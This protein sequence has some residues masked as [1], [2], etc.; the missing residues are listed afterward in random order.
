M[1]L[2]VCPH[3]LQLENRRKAPL[4]SHVKQVSSTVTVGLSILAFHRR[5]NFYAAYI[6]LSQDNGGLMVSIPL[7]H[8]CFETRPLTRYR[9]LQISSS[10]TLRSFFSACSISCMALLGFSRPKSFLKNSSSR[11]LRPSWQQR[12]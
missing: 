5:A 10:F 9:F 3:P 6:S 4:N 7:C 12:S 8:A 1:L 2:Y 11:Q